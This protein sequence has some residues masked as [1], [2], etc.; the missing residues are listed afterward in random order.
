MK[1]TTHTKT[2]KI[3]TCSIALKSVVFNAY[4]SKNKE[5]L[6][7]MH[8]CPEPHTHPKPSFRLGTR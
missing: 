2:G 4:C 3:A 8:C 5:I 6:W 1:F 7:R